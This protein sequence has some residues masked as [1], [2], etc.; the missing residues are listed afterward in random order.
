MGRAPGA[1]PDSRQGWSSV[2]A[3]GSDFGAVGSGEDPLV[4]AA[5]DGDV[6]GVDVVVVVP[7]DQESEVDAGGAV[8]VVPPQAVVDLAFAGRGVAVGEDAVSVAGDDRA[9]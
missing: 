8:L 4:V 7:A 5:G 6:V 1:T 9:G 2:W 3:C